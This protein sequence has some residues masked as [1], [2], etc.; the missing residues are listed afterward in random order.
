MKICRFYHP[1]H[2]ARWGVVQGEAVYDLTAVDERFGAL[3]NLL[4][5]P[6]LQQVL[7]DEVLE[8][9]VEGVPLLLS[10]LD[11][12]P[13]PDAPHLLAPIDEQEVWAAGV[14]Y[15]RSRDARMEE[16]QKAGG[17]TFY[18]K[19]YEADRP[20]LF[21]KATPFRT[22]GPNAAIRIRRDARWNV[23]EPELALVLS[24]DLRLVGYTIGN[25]VSSRDI[26]GENPLYL[27]QAK[28]YVG[29]CALGPVITLAESV[30]DPKRLT[31]QLTI[32]RGGGVMFNGQT[33]IAQMKRTFDDLITYLGRDN[34]FPQGVILLTG[35][36]IVPPDDFTLEEGDE[37]EMT[38]DE[39]GT[40]RNTVKRG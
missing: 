7:L 18:D 15:R 37:V 26:E 39:I 38:I 8:Q 10:D 17:G 34:A 22:V 14:T 5:T 4:N 24:P 19:V 3:V 29:S 28:V 9:A 30:A 35:T 11:R 12:P 40:L 27:P 1:Q 6:G 25:D 32:R 16:S 20:E 31:I 2:G 21:F 36:G 33:S 23:P 13:S